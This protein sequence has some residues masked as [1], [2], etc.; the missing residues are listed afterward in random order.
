LT[1]ETA[2]LE[3]PGPLVGLVI[4][5]A[6]RAAPREACGLLIGIGRRVVRV[7]PTANGATSDSR[8]AIPPEEH[9]AALRQAR[10]EG[11]EVLGAY[12]SHPRSEARPSATDTA[13]AFPSFDFVIVGLTPSP[14]VRAWR[15]VGGNF[16]E[17]GLVGT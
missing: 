12:H 4:A 1:A 14:H 6:Q 2:P 15:F 16:T 17:V 13:E 5:E 3:L 7:V 9:F 11:L 10:G 8:Y